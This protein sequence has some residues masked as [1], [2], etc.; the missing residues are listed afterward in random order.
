MGFAVALSM[1]LVCLRAAW[2]A[3]TV[4]SAVGHRR[5]GAL[6]ANREVVDP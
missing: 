1:T 2:Q 6:T 4:V 3:D 5:A